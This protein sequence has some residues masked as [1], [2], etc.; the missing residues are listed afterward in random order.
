MNCHSLQTI[1]G[2]TS[3]GE[4]QG[5]KWLDFSLKILLQKYLLLVTDCPASPTTKKLRNACEFC[6]TSNPSWTRGS[7]VAEFY[8]LDSSSSSW[9]TGARPTESRSNR[10]TPA[11]I[12]SLTTGAHTPGRLSRTTTLVG[13]IP[14]VH[15]HSSQCNLCRNIFYLTCVWCVYR[16]CAVGKSYYKNFRVLG[17]LPETRGLC[18]L[19]RYLL[20]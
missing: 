14:I 1:L 15:P 11:S 17:P 4:W 5:R 19:I 16:M 12:C 9:A 3:A 10:V 8:C 2:H 6:G 18:A 7:S 20:S 13:G